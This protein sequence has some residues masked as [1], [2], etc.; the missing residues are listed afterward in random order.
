MP[1]KYLRK[2]LVNRYD[3]TLLGWWE[4]L[5]KEYEGRKR[6]EL[7]DK[8]NRALEEKEFEE[9]AQIADTIFKMGVN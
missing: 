9:A 4:E 1:N 5:N 3:K 8:F 6:Q 2:D 7:I